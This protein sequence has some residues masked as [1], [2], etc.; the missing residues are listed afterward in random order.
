MSI[1]NVFDLFFSFIKVW[2]SLFCA[3]K[4]LGINI[5]TLT[6]K[7]KKKKKDYKMEKKVRYF[8]EVSADR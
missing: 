6:K 4:N 3:H 8:S 1:R 2:A 5:A 7:K